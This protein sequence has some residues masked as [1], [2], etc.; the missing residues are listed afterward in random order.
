MNHT[1]WE[2]D[3][4]LDGLLTCDGVYKQELVDAAIEKRAEITPRL[5]HILQ[6]VI[7]DPSE[8]LEDV[9]RMDHIY[10]LMLLGHFG[11]TAAHRTIIDLFSL[12][13]ETAHDL[14]ETIG[15][16][17]L[18]MV[19][20]K[21]CGSSLEAIR[22]MALNRAVD[23]YFR[24]SAFHALVYGVVEGY[25]TRE[26]VLET[27]AAQFTGDEADET[28]D[29]WGLVVCL[30]LDLYPEQIM[31]T[32]DRAFE[33]GLIAP[34]MVGRDDFEKVLAAGKEACLERLHA[35]YGRFSLDDLHASMSW[36]ACFNEKNDDDTPAETAWPPPLSLPLS[37]AQKARAQ[38]PKK[39]KS[40]KKKKRKS[41]RKSKRKNRR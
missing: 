19:L 36:W 25:I 38:K 17:N 9:N 21:T 33:A 28:S 10:A 2:I 12:P 39:L 11:E 29:Y 32:I 4:I 24:V 40:A 27:I 26:A 7:D 6:R 18:P 14:Y 8:Y 16:E 13:G 30:T 3:R 20:I 41:A 35:E 5:I 22:S 15:L 31:D 37:P 34:D 1:N 23:D